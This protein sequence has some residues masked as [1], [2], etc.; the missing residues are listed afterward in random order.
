M[1]QQSKDK[2][3]LHTV[4]FI[5]SYFDKEEMMMMNSRPGS[6][7]EFLPLLLLLLSAAVMYCSFKLVMEEV[8]SNPSV[9]QHSS[10]SRRS[11]SLLLIAE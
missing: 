9:Q 8:E 2:R 5:A 1:Q 11:L 4:V 7:E 6:G 10:C 3:E